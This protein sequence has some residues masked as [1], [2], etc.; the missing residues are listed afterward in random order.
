MT[1]RKFTAHDMQ[2]RKDQDRKFTMLSIYDYPTALIAPEQ[3]A[4]LAK[5]SNGE[6]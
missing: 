2:A 4:Q 1:E 5:S 3:L 6:D